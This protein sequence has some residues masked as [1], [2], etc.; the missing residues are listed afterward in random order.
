MSTIR[1]ISRASSVSVTAVDTSDPSATAPGDGAI[2][3]PAPTAGGFG[4]DA[5]TAIAMLLVR[6][7]DEDRSTA[8][9]A[10]DAADGAALSAANAHA[11]AL[12]DK[13]DQDEYQAFWTGGAQIL[14]GIATGASGFFDGTTNNGVTAA[15]K[16]HAGLSGVAQA[17]PGAGTL[18]AG[19]FRANA[20]R[21][22]ADAARFD[23]QSQVAVRRYNE[24]HD[25]VQSANDS[26]Q[27]VEQFL[28]S[29]A[30][31]A[32]ETRNVAASMLRG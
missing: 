13:A 6:A 4:D 31:S 5:M 7:D 12:H 28:Q 3:L 20:D 26:I 15:S 27:K 9:K 25:D 17:L 14:G 21:H 22:D 30:Q 16:W 24:A 32:N 29:V 18:A 2:L 1:S 11:D 19:F 8:R 23:A 10:E